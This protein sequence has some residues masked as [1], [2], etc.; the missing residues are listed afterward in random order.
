MCKD[1]RFL[2]LSVIHHISI[3]ITIV[4]KFTPII[5]T[6]I[7]TI[8]CQLCNIV[9][10]LSAISSLHYHAL[11]QVSGRQS[12]A[13][14]SLKCNQIS[15]VTHATHATNTRKL[16]TRSSKNNVIM[17]S[18]SKPFANLTMF[19]YFICNLVLAKHCKN[20]ECSPPP[21]F[22]EGSLL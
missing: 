7:M 22:I 12:K 9:C 16:Y 18:A 19:E 5:L 6:E 15:N 10:Q 8:H 20:F 4:I 3:V 11:L 2:Y 17:L 21:L 14:V 1:L 13:T